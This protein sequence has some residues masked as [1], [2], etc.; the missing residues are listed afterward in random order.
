MHRKNA[1]FESKQICNWENK[2]EVGMRGMR[3]FWE[4]CSR[5]TKGTQWRRRDS[6]SRE[7]TELDERTHNASLLAEISLYGCRGEG[8]S[9][10]PVS[11]VNKFYYDATA[12]QWHLFQWSVYDVR[13]EVANHSAVNKTEKN[14][15]YQHLIFRLDFIIAVKIPRFLKACKSIFWWNGINKCFFNNIICMMLCDLVRHSFC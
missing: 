15:F 11:I 14:P 8:N 1:S 9:T 12:G 2:E 10:F 6:H 13:I 5:R 4:C 7:A 3:A